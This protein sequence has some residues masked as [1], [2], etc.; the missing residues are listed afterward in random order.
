MA[1]CMISLSSGIRS[2]ALRPLSVVLFHQ[3]N[4][5]QAQWLHPGCPGLPYL[6]PSFLYAAA[7]KYQLLSGL[8]QRMSQ[9]RF[10]MYGAS[11]GCDMIA[12]MCV[13]RANGV[14]TWVFLL[15]GSSL[16]SLF[17][18]PAMDFAG[19]PAFGQR[20][21]QTSGCNKALQARF[22]ANRACCSQSE[23]A[24]EVIIRSYVSSCST[25][26]WDDLTWRLQ[27]HL[28]YLHISI[29]SLRTNCPPSTPTHTYTRPCAVASPIHRCRSA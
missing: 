28:V 26:F 17:S 13:W 1:R 15:L 27:P 10:M 6:S 18:G 23:T 8:T 21:W 29:S 16:L 9:G 14:A 20:T 5:F 25:R 2:S 11:D 4:I 12:V 22:K 24:D 7:S 3:N 19:D